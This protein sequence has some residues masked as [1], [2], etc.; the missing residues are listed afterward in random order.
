MR[1]RFVLYGLLLLVACVAPTTAGAASVPVSPH[2]A[3]TVTLVNQT[4]QT[5]WVGSPV[6]ADGSAALTGLPTLDS[7]PVRHRRPSRR[8]TGAQHWR[9]TFFARQGCSGP[10]GS[11]FHCGSATAVRPRT[12]APPANSRSAW[13]SSTST[14]PTRLAPWYDVSY[15]N[16]F[17]VPVTITPD[18]V[19]PPPDG[20]SCAT[21]GCPDDLLPYCPSPDLVTDPGTGGSLVCVNPTGTRRPRTATRSDSHCPLAYAW[22]GRTPCRA[23]R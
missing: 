19:A 11:T 21:E 23:T 7:G 22:S 1:I 4:G 20:G 9:G 6:N 3:H 12:T 15:V 10:D 17:S 5:V 16:A 14:R 18:G 13:P 8:T 2:V